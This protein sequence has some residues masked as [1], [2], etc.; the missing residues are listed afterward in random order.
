MNQTNAEKLFQSIAKDYARI[1]SLQKVLRPAQMMTVM[2][3][4]TSVMSNKPAPKEQVAALFRSVDGPQLEQFKRALNEEQ[5]SF[6]VA[7]MKDE[8]VN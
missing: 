4:V 5:Y 1:S 3:I 8:G 6:L 2:A 7:A